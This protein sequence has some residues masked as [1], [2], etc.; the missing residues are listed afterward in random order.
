MPVYRMLRAT[1]VGFYALVVGLFALAVIVMMWQLGAA[2]TPV[3]RAFRTLSPSDPVCASAVPRRLLKIGN[4]ERFLS[5]GSWACYY[6]SHN[7]RAANYDVAVIEFGED[8][9]LLLPQQKTELLNRLKGQKAIVPVFVHGWRHD[10]RAGNRNLEDFRT[11]LSYIDLYR[12][13]RCGAPDNPDPRYCQHKVIGVFAAWRGASVIEEETLDMG[14]SPAKEEEFAFKAIPAYLSFGER[15]TMSDGPLARGIGNVLREIS[16]QLRSEDAGIAEPM[17]RNRMLISGHSLGANIILNAFGAE[18]AANLVKTGQHNI[19]V[20]GYPERKQLVTP[21]AGDLIMLLNPAA[22]AEK[23]TALQ[24]A[25]RKTAGVPDY[26]QTN[27]KSAYMYSDRQGPVMM[28]Y[29]STCDWGELTKD[30]SQ[31]CGGDIIGDKADR[32]R[33]DWATSKVFR[34][35]KSLDLGHWKPEETTALG[36]LL[37]KVAVET[38]K[39]L[40]VGATHEAEINRS[41]EID[42]NYWNAGALATAP[43]ARVDGI[44]DPTEIERKCRHL[45]DLRLP[46]V[47]VA[48]ETPVPN[49]QL[50]RGVFRGCFNSVNAGACKVNGV[51]TCRFFYPELTTTRD[52][53]WN[54]RVIN[55]II[56]GHNAVFQ[57]HLWCGTNQFLLDRTVLSGP[58]L[59]PI[60]S[61]SSPGPPSQCQP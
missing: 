10:A 48:G 29:T 4:R 11:L 21:P 6:Q 15:K 54:V 57:H 61:P 42:T 26:A 16:D 39:G 55:D 9:R 51:Q 23:W 52:P 40:R 56:A 32:R 14:L 34:L 53:F 28:A 45:W 17:A 8:G 5:D 18:M 22:E 59:P 12:Q 13:E 3:D 38:G 27:V 19:S 50:R 58:G 36:H 60:G 31:K 33:C 43:C 44:Y 46:F 37:G 35:F 7:N 47:P 20:V 41:T 30:D 1:L 2:K 49:W 24:H 25:A